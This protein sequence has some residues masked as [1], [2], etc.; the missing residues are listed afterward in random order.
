MRVLLARNLES[1]GKVGDVVEVKR[2]Y[3]RN[4][5][6]PLGLAHEV[7]AE[8]LSRIE[9][10]RKRFE[11]EELK[12]LGNLKTLA[13]RIATSNVT[14]E[15]KASPEGHLYGSVTAAMIAAELSKLGHQLAAAA[16]RLETPIKQVG[17]F[18]VPVHLHKDVEAEARVWVVQAKE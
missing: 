8:N 1:L 16:V 9:I 13:E 17:V 11:A 6:L 5:L 4:Y 3:A 14:I 7:T 18:N 10:E 12:R 15:A 2:G